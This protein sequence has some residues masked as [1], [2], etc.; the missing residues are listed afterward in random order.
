MW[1]ALDLVRVCVLA[2]LGVALLSA[3]QLYV[4]PR[5]VCC[6]LQAAQT[7]SREDGSRITSA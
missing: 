6:P 7:Q 3:L 4:R 1:D 2:S 5:T